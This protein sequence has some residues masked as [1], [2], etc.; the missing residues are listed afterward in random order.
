MSLA[1]GVCFPQTCSSA[2]RMFASTA[3][4][5]RLHYYWWIVSESFPQQR[6][7]WNALE[8]GVHWEMNPRLF[9]KYPTPPS[10]LIRVI[11]IVGFE[12]AAA[13][14][15][16]DAAARH[17]SRTAVL[18]IHTLRSALENPYW[19]PIWDQT[20]KSM[21]FDLRL[22]VWSHQNVQFQIRCVK[23]PISPG[24]IGSL[25]YAMSG[26]VVVQSQIGRGRRPIWQSGEKNRFATK[27]IRGA[28]SF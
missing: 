21:K 17:K 10:K 13:E 16:P 4:R 27:T 6:I 20:M 5:S 24:Q 18:R 7:R 15:L 19:C 22:D 3:S 11:L 25:R 12:R 26:K 9:E 2:G 14:G 8:T 1:L 28:S 23:C